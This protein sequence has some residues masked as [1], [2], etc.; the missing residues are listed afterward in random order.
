MFADSISS[1]KSNE[2]SPVEVF[3]QT[4]RVLTSISA[5][6]VGATV[7]FIKDSSSSSTTAFGFSV[8]VCATLSSLLLMN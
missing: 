8:F 1:V 4:Q 5:V 2:I 7:D 3:Q 6:R